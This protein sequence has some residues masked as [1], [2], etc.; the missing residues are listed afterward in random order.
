MQVSDEITIN[1]RTIQD[2]HVGGKTYHCEV[3]RVK[4]DQL[5]FDLANPRMTGKLIGLENYSVEEYRKQFT[6]AET[7]DLMRQIVTAGGLI[8]RPFVQ[9]CKGKPDKIKF[10]IREGNR[11]FHVLLT[12]VDAIQNEKK[13]LGFDNL[14]LEDYDTIDVVVYPED[15]KEKD[16]LVHLSTLHVKGKKD[17][18]AW[19]KAGTVKKMLEDLGMSEN[20]VAQAIGI[21]KSYIDLYLWAYDKTLEYHNGVGKDDKKWITRF[22]HFMKLYSRRALRNN[23]ITEKENMDM[24]MN[25]VKED[26]IKHAFRISGKIGLEDV[27]DDKQV[28]EWF[29]VGKNTLN[30]AIEKIKEKKLR[31]DATDNMQVDIKSTIHSL[32]QVLP[33]MTIETAR[34]IANDPNELKIYEETCDLLNNRMDEISLSKK[35]SK[36]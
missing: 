6:R 33:K 9:K 32:H 7:L 34:E 5:E 11:R 31:F 25:W 27:L 17:W 4:I 13:V 28:Y 19:V 14:R 26:K 2:I 16:I 8:E 20:D 30:D 29:K 36:K 22:S 3:I 18:D 21:S 1:Q 12:I 24:F 15:M 10:T 35:I 23:W